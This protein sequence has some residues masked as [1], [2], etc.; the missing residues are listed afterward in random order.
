MA[1]T[2]MSA[3]ARGAD[4]ARP[5]KSRSDYGRNPD[6]SRPTGLSAWISRLVILAVL[7]QIGR[8][9]CRERV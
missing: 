5:L 6:G 8:A 1:I 4:T 9:S 7:A 3:P 2:P